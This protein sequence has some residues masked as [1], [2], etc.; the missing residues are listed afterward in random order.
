[1]QVFG[2]SFYTKE[3]NYNKQRAVLK[4]GVVD[5]TG[6]E[7][8]G[9]FHRIYRF[10]TF[11]KDQRLIGVNR[12]IF[13]HNMI[14]SVA[15][16][17][18]EGGG[19]AKANFY[20]NIVKLNDQFVK[21]NQM[22]FLSG[23]I[24]KVINIVRK[25][26]GFDPI[27]HYQ[28]LNIEELK[29]K[30]DV[31]ID[32]LIVKTERPPDEIPLTVSFS[33]ATLPIPLPLA[34]F[35][36]GNSALAPYQS[37]PH[38]ET[39]NQLWDQM[40]PTQ[41]QIVER[42]YRHNELMFNQHFFD[43]AL[44]KGHKFQMGIKAQGDVTILLDENDM[45]A[46]QLALTGTDDW[47]GRL[48]TCML[49][50]GV[51]EKAL[52]LL[53]WVKTNHASPE[54][55]AHLLL[56]WMDKVS[57]ASQEEEKPES[58]EEA[59]PASVEEA[60]PKKHVKP[61]SLLDRITDAENPPKLSIEGKTFTV[62]FD[63]IKSEFIIKNQSDVALPLK[64]IGAILGGQFCPAKNP[65]PITLINREDKAIRNKVVTVTIP[66]NTIYQLNYGTSAFT[67][68]YESMSDQ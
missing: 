21:G 27:G 16:T 24:L 41:Q 2:I 33:N 67:I 58:V 25:I 3:F 11:Q 4:K 42:L 31:R 54:N 61:P 35:F 20:Y 22:N 60:K 50:A 49:L 28:V 63:S 12:M 45:K 18:I 26:F 8:E 17:L 38:I 52:P 68:S 34:P 43:L 19:A 39:L 9:A 14:D 7:K 1:M 15:L 56:S 57:E 32:Q 64:C 51:E 44:P 36:S 48:L 5:V 46:L 40:P 59:K 30:I 55:V 10:F 6:R 66:S 13:S 29:K 47:Q 37:M 53:D 23:L 65:L 62:G